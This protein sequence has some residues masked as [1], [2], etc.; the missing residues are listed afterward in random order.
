MTRFSSSALDLSNVDPLSLW[1][2]R[3]FSDIRAARIADLKVRLTNAGIPWDVDTIE[4]DPGAFLQETGAFR[5][6]L[7]MAAVDDAQKKVLLAFAF[8]KWLDRL[9]DGQ[10]TA[11]LPGESD[12]RYRTR[13]QLAPESFASA[14]TAGGYIYWASSVSTDVRDVGLT[15]LNRGTPNVSVE[16]VILS[17]VEP[18][19]PSDDLMH[20]VRTRLYA[21]DVKLLTDVV[22]VRPAV[23][24]E[25]D[26]V[27]TQYIRPGPD[28]TLVTSLATTSLQSMG[29]RYKRLG[30]AVPRNAIDA[31]LYVPNVDRVVVT[32]PAADFVPQRWQA[33]DLRNVTLKTVIS[34][35]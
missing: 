29:D 27:A 19:V 35:D 31:S 33:A 21:D 32:S 17:A 5:E 1:P 2:T 10:G 20:A 14:G 30:G 23:I 34:T 13:I 7:T 22:N 25:Y 12:D 24:I 18:G 8:G 11:R 4:T 9:G 15:V 3:S 6:L 26:V 16:V 28:P